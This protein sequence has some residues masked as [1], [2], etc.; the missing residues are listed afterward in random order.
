MSESC[1]PNGLGSPGRVAD[2]GVGR[3][4]AGARRPVG[5]AG[6]PRSARPIPALIGRSIGEVVQRVAA[7]RAKRRRLAQAL[8]DS[9]SLLIDGRS[10][11]PRAVGDLLIALR[12]AGAVTISPPV[13]A[14]CGKALRT[15]QRRGEH[16]Y[17]GVC[18]PRLEPC[19]GCGQTRRSRL[20][21]PRGRTVVRCLPTG[22]RHRLDADPARDHHRDRSRPGPGRGDR[23]DRRR[24][25]GRVGG[26][27]WRGPCRT[28]PNCSPAPAPRPVCPR[29]CG[30][31][32]RS[33]RP[34]RAVSCV[35]AA[36][37]AAG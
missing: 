19:V 32:T 15:L 14:D 29:C 27:N 34:G 5:G 23:R 21:R 35:P 11:A 31:S 36:H 12:R 3:L 10:P 37:T 18:G 6:G 17:C 24:R 33:S 26:T 2:R 7:G 20:P 30:S 13:C 9:P 4:T 16:W 28:G 22:R 8:L 1:V 25:P